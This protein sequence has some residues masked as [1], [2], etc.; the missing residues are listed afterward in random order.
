MKNS[1]YNIKNISFLVLIL[2]LVIPQTRQPIQI[3]LNKGLA[4]FSPSVNS[5]DEVE[6]I[7]NYDWQLVNLK[8]EEFNLNQS[9]SRVVQMRQQPLEQEVFQEHF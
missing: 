8:G 9:K 2:L 3:F 7:S 4:L 6:Q 5:L 1:K